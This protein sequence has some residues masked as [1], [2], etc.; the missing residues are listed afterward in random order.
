MIRSESKIISFFAGHWP[1]LLNNLTAKELYSPYSTSVRMH[2]YNSLQLINWAFRVQKVLVQ[3]AFCFASI[4]QSSYYV[5]NQAYL[6]LCRK[7]LHKTKDQLFRLNTPQLHTF[8]LIS[9]SSCVQQQFQFSSLDWNS[10]WPDLTKNALCRILA[11]C[12]W[13]D[14]C[15]CI[16]DK[17]IQCHFARI[18]WTMIPRSGSLS[19]W[20]EWW[21]IPQER[22]TEDHWGW[23]GGYWSE[24][25]EWDRQQ[26][27]RKISQVSYICI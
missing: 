1:R 2:V 5:F 13:A 20:V 17:M 26:T 4:L 19:S 22:L 10:T 8:H 16:Y 7:H 6:R 9:I 14:H 11:V 12:C 27:D 24:D 15:I 3:Q 18:F 23:D 25:Y 21:C